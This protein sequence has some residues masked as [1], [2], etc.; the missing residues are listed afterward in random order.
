MQLCNAC[1]VPVCG[2]L[3][4]VSEYHCVLASSL[5]GHVVLWARVF[6]VY[7]S[8]RVRARVHLLVYKCVSVCVQLRKCLGCGCE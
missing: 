6:C 4:H 8:V 3:L 1:T 2:L 7:V 5:V